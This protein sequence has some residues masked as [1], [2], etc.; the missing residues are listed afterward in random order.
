MESLLPKVLDFGLQMP[1]GPCSG[2]VAC[3]VLVSSRLDCPGVSL[4]TCLE[5]SMWSFSGGV[6]L[7]CC[8]SI[9]FY[10]LKKIVIKIILCCYPIIIH[11]SCS[12]M[13]VRKTS[14][15]NTS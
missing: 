9:F 14:I 3:I 12:T 6:T 2:V 10:Q 4:A 11:I 7:K 8:S 15:Y 5:M 1:T 13:E